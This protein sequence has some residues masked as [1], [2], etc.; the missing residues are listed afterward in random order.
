MSF[1]SD[2]K[3][4]LVHLSGHE[5]HCV[6]AEL[7]AIICFSAKVSCSES[8]GYHII[9]ETENIAV[10]KRFYLLLKKAFCFQPR[11]VVSQHESGK[12]SHFFTISAEGA[13]NVLQVLKTAGLMNNRGQV[14][15]DEY[16]TDRKSVV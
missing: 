14:D 7:A 12:K 1:S 4:E 11:V 16:L 10:A 9:L 6:V 5:L 15:E 3:E 2:V 13:A 8:S